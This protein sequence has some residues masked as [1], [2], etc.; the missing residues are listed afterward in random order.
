MDVK[1]RAES[2]TA[3]IGDPA[4]RGKV[5]DNLTKFLATLDAIPDDDEVFPEPE[6]EQSW[7]DDASDGVPLLTLDDISERERSR[8]TNLRDLHEDMTREDEPATTSVLE[9]E[10]VAD[11]NEQGKG[12]KTALHRAVIAADLDLV[13]DLLSRGAR[14]DIEDKSGM[15]ALDRAMFRADDSVIAGR[16]AALLSV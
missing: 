2:I 6:E 4:L 7:R 1:D 13:S 11:V 14:K 8:L 9:V 3:H 10:V 16:I 15:T 12:G 5:K